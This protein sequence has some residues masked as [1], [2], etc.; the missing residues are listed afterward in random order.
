MK[1]AELATIILEKLI[2]ET[3]SMTFRNKSV[4]PTKTVP[5]CS[6]DTQVE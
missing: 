3:D 2:S 1:R 6:I 4:T 5:V